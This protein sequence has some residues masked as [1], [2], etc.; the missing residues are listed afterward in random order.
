M[1][2][3]DHFHPPLS[4]THTWEGFHG[5]WPMV[6]VQQL[7]SV[8][9]PGYVAEPHVHAG[10]MVAV[11]VGTYERD[12]APTNGASDEGG[13]VAVA[14]RAWA[15]P[16]PAVAAETDLPEQGDYGVRVAAKNLFRL[17]DLPN[18]K[19][20]TALAKPWEPYRS[21]ASWYLWRSL[22]QKPKK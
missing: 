3:R 13:G 9:P 17:R 22:E 1:P 2:L 8:L 11:D 15:A 20:L 19:K 21:I 14:V 5:G 16:R 6:I 18:A 10:P 7:R 4:E 12:R